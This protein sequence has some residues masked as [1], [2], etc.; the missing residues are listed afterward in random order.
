MHRTTLIRVFT[1]ALVAVA[2]VT[3][4]HH[5]QAMF[6]ETPVW[7]T[8]T[9][10]RY[11]PVDPHAMIELQEPQPAGPGRKWIVEGPRR[12]RLEWI[13]QN[14]GGIG[15]GQIL[16]VG[17][18][19][20]VCGFPLQKDF[21]AARMYE[22]WPPEQER[23]VHGQVIVMPNG[24]MQSWGPYG[25]IDNCVRRGDTAR[26]WIR[27]LDRDPLARRLWC[28]AMGNTGLAQ[29]APRAIIGEINRG[30]GASCAD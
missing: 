25:K 8:G 11:R 5:S 3:A 12:G 14:N 13:L 4:A 1:L 22:D 23:F 26:T 24:Q 29:P 20:A 21:A 7:I 17:D 19:I 28:A 6:A 9:I 27:F 18:R 2:A 15:D 30:L 10:V 16:K